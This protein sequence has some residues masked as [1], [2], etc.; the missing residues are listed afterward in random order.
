M[1][2]PSQFQKMSGEDN[3]ELAYVLGTCS[4]DVGLPLTAHF[5]NFLL[6]VEV[7]VIVLADTANALPQLAKTRTRP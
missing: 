7:R 4:S 3:I 5:L 6:V 1:L 2:A